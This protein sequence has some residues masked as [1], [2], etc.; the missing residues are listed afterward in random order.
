MRKTIHLPPSLIRGAHY[1][2]PSPKVPR[3]HAFICTR[4]DMGECTLSLCG[5]EHRNI[6]TTEYLTACD[7][8]MFD[9]DTCEA[10]FSRLMIGG[11]HI[12]LLT[13]KEAGNVLLYLNYRQKL[14]AKG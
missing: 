3:K 1:R 5:E 2:P 11:F 7:I 12:M 4:T 6:A 14:L 8:V 13:D 9:L 10:H